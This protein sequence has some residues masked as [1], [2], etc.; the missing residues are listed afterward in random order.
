MKIDMQLVYNHVKKQS[1]KRILKRCLTELSQKYTL[2]CTKKLA[3]QF[4]KDNHYFCPCTIHTGNR[5][6]TLNSKG[7]KV[8]IILQRAHV[9]VKR[10]DIINKIIETHPEKTI[11]DLLD[12]VMQKHIHID[13]VFA[14]QTCN[15]KLE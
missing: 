13:I 11:C 5:F 4:K 14:C 9:G 8:K 7:K 3:K 10:S 1:K 12:L 2:E 15:K 6:Y